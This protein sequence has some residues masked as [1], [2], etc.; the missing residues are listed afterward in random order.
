ML[1]P[2][3]YLLRLFQGVKEVV[4][5]KRLQKLVFLLQNEGLPMGQTFIFHYYGPYSPSLAAEVEALKQPSLGLL[6]EEST[7]TRSGATEYHYRL[8]K[9]GVKLL[10]DFS[11]NSDF[12]EDIACTQR[13]VDRF[14]ELAVVNPRTLELAS[15]IV[16]WMQKGYSETE[17]A[18]KTAKLKRAKP[19]GTPFKKATSIAR[20]SWE[21]R[22]NHS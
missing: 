8:Q 16:Y 14:A 1:P 22:P 10:K 5:R 11:K 4:G 3:F 7:S 13:F 15:T 21:K 18:E 19:E 9:S 6:K 17:A 2:A 12:S 20:E